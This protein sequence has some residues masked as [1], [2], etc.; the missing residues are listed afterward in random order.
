MWPYTFSQ[1]R[2]QLQSTERY[3][4][5]GSTER[6]G[7]TFS[8]MAVEWQ[9]NLSNVQLQSNEIYEYNSIGLII[10]GSNERY[11][12]NF[13]QIKRNGYNLSQM[14]VQPQ[15][16]KKYGRYGIGSETPV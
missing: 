13:S 3:G 5:Y 14:R 15:S 10:Y 9:C 2:V 8:R 6:Y 12:Y 11:G 7:Y 1:L 16:N 4:R